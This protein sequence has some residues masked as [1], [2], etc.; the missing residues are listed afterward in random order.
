V[1]LARDQ[2]G[3]EVAIKYLAPDLVADEDFRSGF[4]DE[5]RLLARLNA[6]NVVRVREYLES[7]AESSGTE[8][9]GAESSGG[10]SSG[11]E[12][13][14]EGAAL[15]MDL[16]NGVSLAAV[17]GR[18]G[19]AVPE[20]ALHVLK[21]SLRGLAAAHAVGVVHGDY[22]PAN[23][24]VTGAGESK[25][26]GFGIP[27]LE[28]GAGAGSGTPAYL[29][30]EQW[31]GAAAD[32]RTDIYAATCAFVECMTGRP[33]YEADDLTM[34][35]LHHESAPIPDDRVPE[36]VRGLVRSGLAKDP[37]DRPADAAA[38]LVELEAAAVAG[39]REDWAERGRNALGRR[40]VL[41]GLPF[42][43]AGDSGSTS[44]RL[45]EAFTRHQ[46]QIAVFAAVAVLVLTIGGVVAAVNTGGEVDE[47]S[48]SPADGSRRAP[49]PLLDPATPRPAPGVPA[50]GGA[51]PTPVAAPPP[52]PV[53][54]PRRPRPATTG[55][56]DRSRASASRSRSRESESR[57][58]SRSSE[59]R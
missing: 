21:E 53:V 33:L 48:V 5:S 15:V 36:P 8:S 1:V 22:R 23:V 6:P 31:S 16:V 3:T 41:L 28:D 12:S 50:G 11:A 58:A 26:I 51:T 57:R 4:G 39:Y 55:D 25:L 37:A 47:A 42:P 46:P 13:S 52:R 9:S 24:L 56:D 20:S 54:E 7:G 45:A 40:A 18:H 34:L 32:P 44:S 43:A 17:L 14:G 10:E 38:F 29:A 35:R 19:P 49:L 27:C 2:S 30:P 59:N